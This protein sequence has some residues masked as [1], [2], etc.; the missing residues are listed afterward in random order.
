MPLAVLVCVNSQ[1]IDWCHTTLTWYLYVFVISRDLDVSS[2]IVKILIRTHNYFPDSCRVS[3]CPVFLLYVN[4]A[5]LAQI[6]SW[7]CQ[8]LREDYPE[9]EHRHTPFHHALFLNMYAT[10]LYNDPFTDC[11]DLWTWV[12]NISGRPSLFFYYDGLRAIFSY[13]WK[14]FLLQGSSWINCDFSA[15]FRRVSSLI[16]LPRISSSS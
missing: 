13:I 16:L 4:I 2:H 15:I 14:R 1:E 7:V 11:S 5:D 12:Q 6:Q 3:M 10:N 9:Q 8:F